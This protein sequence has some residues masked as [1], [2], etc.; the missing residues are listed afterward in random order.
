MLQN[1]VLSQIKSRADAIGVSLKELAREAGLDPT[2][3]YRGAK[4]G[5]DFRQSTPRRLL[6]VLEPREKKVLVALARLYPGL[7]IQAANGM[8]DA[9]RPDPRQTDLEDFTR[10]AQQRGEAA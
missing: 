8:A 9:D 4:N 1:G 6:Q 5:S 10:A 7:A 3:I 2:N